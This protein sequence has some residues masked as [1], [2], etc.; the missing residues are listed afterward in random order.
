[1]DTRGLIPSKHRAF[2]LFILMVALVSML[3]SSSPV[4]Y[5]EGDAE[6]RPAEGAINGDEEHFLGLKPTLSAGASSQQIFI[7]RFFMPPLAAST[8]LSSEL[9]PVGNQGGQGSCVAWATSYYYKSWLE[10]KEH[11]GWSLSNPYYQ[12]SPSFVYNQI[13]G[14]VD[15]GSYFEDAFSLMENDGD[16]DIA[17]M[18]YSQNDYLTQPSAATSQAAEPY[19]I[20]G[21]WGYFWIRSI[22]GPYSSPNNI[23]SI[24]TWL[25]NGNI[26]VMGI[27]IYYDFPSFAG[28]P[29]NP[30]YDYNGT[31]GFAGGHGVCIAGYD[32]NANPSG[33]DADH[34]GGFKMVNSWG[35]NW[36]GTSHGYVYL[37]YDFVK[38]YVWEAWSM[39]DLS[40][41]SPGITSLSTSSGNIGSTIH[42]Y[43]NNFGTYRR[44]AG[45]AFNGTNAGSFS[46]TNENITV[47][48]PAGA[49]SGPLVVYDWEGTT[50]NAVQFNIGGG[51]ASFSVDAS[52]SGGHG[53][54]VESHQEV[55]AGG[56][57][58]IHINPDSGYHISSI[59]DNGAAVAIANPYILSNVQ[60]NHNIIIAFVQDSQDIRSTFYF[61]EGCTRWGFE[62][63]LSVLNTGASPATAY[64]TYIFTNGTTMSQE[65]PLAASSRTSLKVNDVVGP[66]KD[67]SV[68]ITS[69]GE[70]VAERPMYFNYN[71]IWSGGHD[72]IGATTPLTAF[73][74]AEG[75]TRPGFDQWL[76]LMNPGD[77]ATTAH[78]TYMF[79]DGT[80]QRQ[81]VT[82]GATTRS[83]IK[84][85]NV[86]GRDRD[87]SVKITSDAPII[88]ERPIY[89]N[90]MGRYTGGHDVI[91]AA[92]PEYS[93]YF[94][95]G[96]TGEGF[97]E[98]LCLMNPGNTPAT[99]RITYLFT[100]G[101]SAFQDIAIGSTS[102][103]TI[104]VNGAIGPDKDVS[105]KIE[106]DQPIVA[107][108]P[109][110]FNY[111]G[112]W[113]G[114]HDVI[115]ANS[116]AS[117]F[118]FAEGYTGSNFDE[119]LCLMNPGDSPT[120]AHITYIYADGYIWTHDISIA[121][122]SRAT[123]YV[124][125]EAGW[126][127]GVSVK[128]TS[129]SPILAE[130]PM[131]FNYG[132]KWTG[133]HDV[134]G[135]TP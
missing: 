84:V 29:A 2:F 55:N 64:I 109:I 20:A 120:E 81:D 37:S 111:M 133:G 134:I 10:S 9:P 82:I 131:Y 32:D 70:I 40:P 80:V 121:A 42:V 107:E 53:A 119:W 68:K 102:R 76:C 6:S 23:D 129:D 118:Y 34:R 65:V 101:R 5:A 85:N 38:R 106:S 16:T 63:W 45:V 50:S 98:W 130:R 132:W 75:C 27:P 103:A 48:V 24:K 116:P 90:Y 25:N 30:Y 21:N 96:Y 15:G 67:V 7:S 1:M 36:N 99:A 41:D 71:G 94:A 22:M 112:M 28:N 52:V 18:P 100:D 43:G 62:E 125:E 39:N 79:T 117:S 78:I 74:F 88:A 127:E 124:N 11:T 66:D 33:V 77:N 104:S 115:G 89:F 4:I 31:S 3:F 72:V 35:S 128:I 49:S 57:A 46:F 87:V 73:Y 56:T 26:L 8:D 113:T 83:T 92:S 12:F 61:A 47:T 110:Y 95:E 122:S 44:S 51:A 91:G 123:V 114:G 14:G 105:V 86:V 135:Y 58:S 17:Q 54:V 59:S 19:R 108:R 93:F 60:E 69:D 97:D 13:N 126:Y